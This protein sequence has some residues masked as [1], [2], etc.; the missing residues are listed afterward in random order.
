MH[1]TRLPNAV[2]SINSC[3]GDVACANGTHST[4]LPLHE[5]KTSSFLMLQMATDKSCGKELRNIATGETDMLQTSFPSS[6]LY[7]VSTFSIQLLY[8]LYT[9]PPVCISFYTPCH[10]RHPAAVRPW[11]LC[12]SSPVYLQ[13]A[14]G[15]FRMYVRASCR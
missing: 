10:I 11:H 2:D 15:I 5:K 7:S 13:R 6:F 12:P 8:G 3:L 4:K 14:F 1:D 9:P